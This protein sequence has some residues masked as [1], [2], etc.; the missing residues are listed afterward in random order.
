MDWKKH[1]EHFINGKMDEDFFVLGVDLGDAT[2]AISYFDPLR[3]APEILDIS[4]GYGKPCPPTALQHITAG[5]EWI[6]G[7]YAILNANGSDAL[8]TN[9]AGRLG[10]AA[11]LDIGDGGKSVIEIVSIYLRELIGNCR[12]INPK[13]TV[14]GITAVV[15]DFIASD[16]RDAL[17]AAFG[18]AGYASSLIG[19][20]EER[21]A[22]LYYCA[23]NGIGKPHGNILW[24]DFGSRGMR[25]GLYEI[26]ADFAGITCLASDF[27]QE[28]GCA[29]IDEAI[30]NLLAIYYCKEQGVQPDKMTKREREQI[31]TFAHSYRDML[32]NQDGGRDTK[33]YYNFVHPP[34][35]KTVT[36]AQI[37]DMTK[38]WEK[39]LAEFVKK[40]TTGTDGAHIDVICTGGGFEMPWARRVVGEIFPATHFHKNP[41]GILAGGA[42]LYAANQ[43]SLIKLPNIIIEDGNKLPFDVGINIVQQG[44]SNFHT[45][46]ERGSWLWQK[47]KTAHLIARGEDAEVELL[48]R[49]EKGKTRPLG[50]AALKGLPKR[51]AGTTRIALD[52]EAKTAETFAVRVKDLGFGEIFPATGYVE[53][54][55]FDADVAR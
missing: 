7:E 5:R 2:S 46:M 1:R 30:Y 32:L 23:A 26:G 6:F 49:D 18:R 20:I 27:N 15:P 31:F 53:N 36:Q 25:G 16:A 4:G 38:P 54:Y 40:L 51:P 41:K 8:L 14:A 43:L 21:Q 45:L 22:V 50:T 24:L 29:D 37:K 34:F 12:N 10:E 9:F 44:K 48:L 11:Y 3:G 19:L 35:A 28:M 39:R 42:T 13:A 33:L 52:L 55:T 17:T 47:P